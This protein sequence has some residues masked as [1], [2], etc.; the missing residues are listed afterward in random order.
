MTTA[1]ITMGLSEAGVLYWSY[2][3]LSDGIE[4]SPRN[5]A[6]YAGCSQQAIH[7]HF[8]TLIQRGDLLREGTPRGGYTYQLVK[9]DLQRDRRT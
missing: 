2:R 6:K 9:R 4:L 7:K 1:T 5:V 8:R 3:V